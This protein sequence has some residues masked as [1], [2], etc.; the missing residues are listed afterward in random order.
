MQDVIKTIFG[1]LGTAFIYLLGGLDVA[2][3][4]LLVAIVL[5][6]ITGLSKSYVNRK[7]DSR[8]GFNGIVKKLCLLCLVAL[9]VVID[10]VAGNTGLIRTTIIYYLVANE[11]LSII[12]NLS[13]M[14]IIVP[15]FLKSKLKKMQ[16]TGGIEN[17]QK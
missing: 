15:E 5:D 17:G 16:E 2:L 12:E 8:I 4:A 3:Q 11:G 1:F 6:Y 7:L 13:E 10:N 9:S 14:N